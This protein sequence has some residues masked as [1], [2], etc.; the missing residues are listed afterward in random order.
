MQ[1]AFCILFAKFLRKMKNY[2]KK[3]D[4]VLSVRIGLVN[5]F[6]ICIF[7]LVWLSTAFRYFGTF[8][9]LCWAYPISFVLT[10]AIFL[11][12]YFPTYQRAKEK[13]SVREEEAV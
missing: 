1:E 8:Y 4:G 11:V 2:A 6:G 13:L 5:L 10:F 3:A 12:L 9:S 7:R